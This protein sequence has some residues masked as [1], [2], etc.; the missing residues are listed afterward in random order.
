MSEAPVNT[1]LLKEMRRY[2]PVITYL[3]QNYPSIWAAATQGTGI[4]TANGYKAAIQ[5]AEGGKQ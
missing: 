5:A 2:L 1:Q 3:E 4:A